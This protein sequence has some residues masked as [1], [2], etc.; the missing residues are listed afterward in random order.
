MWLVA[1]V[2]LSGDDDDQRQILL[3]NV[4]EPMG[5]LAFLLQGAGLSCR[6]L[7]TNDTS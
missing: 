3:V 5:T 7:R 4:G 1:L 6:A 2:D